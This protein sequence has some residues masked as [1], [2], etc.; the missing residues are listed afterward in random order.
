MLA[1]LAA[2]ADAAGARLVTTEKDWTRLAPVWRER[3]VAWPVSVRIDD[4][5]AARQ[6]LLRVLGLE[7]T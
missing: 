7:R 4:E 2:R 6:T 3:V 5:G 1:R